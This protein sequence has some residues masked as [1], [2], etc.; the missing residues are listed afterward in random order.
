MTRLEKK[1]R[2]AELSGQILTGEVCPRCGDGWLV[3]KLADSVRPF[4]GCSTFNPH[5]SSCRYTTSFP[6]ER[7][8]EFPEVFKKLQETS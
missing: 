2:R 5:R 6:S 8:G 4:V 1:R 7:W 3:V